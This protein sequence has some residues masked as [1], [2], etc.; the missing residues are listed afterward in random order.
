[1]SF[2]SASVDQGGPLW[3]SVDPLVFLST[4]SRST[5]LWTAHMCCCVGLKQQQQ[6][7]KAAL[8]DTCL[9]IVCETSAHDRNVGEEDEEKR[10]MERRVA[11]LF[12]WQLQRQEEVGEGSRGDHALHCFLLLSSH[13]SRAH[14]GGWEASPPSWCTVTPCPSPIAPPPAAVQHTCSSPP[15]LQFQTPT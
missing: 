10:R 9:T 5:H 2:P 4:S 1:M 15:A 8:T 11:A 7:K 3:I 14:T 12:G 6:K 13:M